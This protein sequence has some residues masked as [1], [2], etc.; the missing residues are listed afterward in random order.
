MRTCAARPRQTSGRRRSESRSRATASPMRWRLSSFRPWLT[1]FGSRFVDVHR[2][3]PGRHRG[4]FLWVIGQA[5]E[6]EIFRRHRASGEH[7]LVHPVQQTAP[8]LG[9][10]QNDREVFDLSG[11]RQR[12]RFEQLV[13]GSKAAWKDDE[14]ARV[15]DEHVL[16]HEEVP[17]LDTEVD[18]RIE[19]LLARELDVAAHRKAAGLVAA[20]VDRLHHPRPTAGDDRE[21]S[22]RKGGTEGSAQRVVMVVRFGTRRAE[23]RHSGPDVVQ[24]VET[25]DELGQDAQHAPWV[26]MVAQLL[27][28]AAFEQHLVGRRRLLGDDET[29]GAAAIRH[30]PRQACGAGSAA[31]AGSA[32]ASGAVTS[33]LAC[34]TLGSG[35]AAGLARFFRSPPL[36][37]SACGS[38][39]AATVAGSSKGA[40]SG[41]I[42]S[43]SG[44]ETCAG[45]LTALPEWSGISSTW[46]RWARKDATSA[47]SS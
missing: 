2:K 31:S 26:G 45:A 1:R 43:A 23:H 18:V 40:S 4:C 9:A 41:A 10:E 36:L 35:A 22:P 47:S 38:G 3:R 27:D 8:V 6:V 19:L 33:P 5:H 32:V 34:S 28:S 14:A 24:R 42:S 13:K 12:E 39:R 21:A 17:E 7:D 37:P 11:L 15:L 30:D 44:S 20:A 46:S 29:A 25:F 16:A